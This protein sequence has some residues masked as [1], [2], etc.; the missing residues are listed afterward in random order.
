ML[1]KWT[2]L[3]PYKKNVLLQRKCVLFI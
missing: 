3:S 1:Y 2:Q